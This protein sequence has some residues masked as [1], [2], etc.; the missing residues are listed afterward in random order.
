MSFIAG[1]A[2]AAKCCGVDSGKRERFD[3]L[4][5]HALI[6]TVFLPLLR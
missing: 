6:T 5:A 1:A 3:L 2:R 4:D